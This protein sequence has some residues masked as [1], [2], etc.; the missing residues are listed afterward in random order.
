MK[1]SK[2]FFR[3][4]LIGGAIGDALGWPVEFMKTNEIKRQYGE[5]G[6]QDLVLKSGYAEITDDTQ[7]TLFTAEGILRTMTRLAR[8]GITSHIDVTYY[9]YMRWL[10]TQGYPKILDLNW[11]Y[12]GYLI[13]QKKLHQRR[14]PGNSCISALNSGN[15]RCIEN[16]INDS[17]GCGGVMRMA[18][19]GL[20]LDKDEA[21][22]VG[23]ELAALTHGH[24]TGFTAAGAF[25]LIISSI[26][27]GND[28]ETAA[29]DALTKLR[30][31][32]HPMDTYW[33]L[34]RA[35]KLSKEN[36]SDEEAISELGGGWIAEEALAIGV[37]CAI[38]YQCDFR[39]GIIAAV[40]HDGDSDSTG[41]ITGNL[42]GAYL[43]INEIPKEW[44]EKVELKEVIEQVSD[45]LLL[46]K[47]DGDDVWERWPGY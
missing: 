44:Q 10:H 34:F 35:T 6:I 37:F 18:P 38:R 26:I 13:G 22:Q 27:E 32:G 39:K 33:K 8:K 5:K 40:N 19:V 43:G 24:K 21:F 7:M 11:I 16:P 23:M 46:D 17:K 2:D 9:A 29:I 15:R 25:A 1:K 45:D 12:D 14:A 30:H 20:Y 4:C 28:I 36:I 31:F 41:S 42:L 47:F 3:G